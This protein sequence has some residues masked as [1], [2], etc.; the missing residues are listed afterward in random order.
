MSAVK[1]KGGL[2][3]D[4][5]SPTRRRIEDLEEKVEDL[6]EKIKLNN[7]RINHAVDR[8]NELWNE[9]VKFKRLVLEGKDEWQGTMLGANKDK[10]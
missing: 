9:I 2:Y 5:R 10:K 8:Y 7:K 4:D 1:D 3:H 6:E